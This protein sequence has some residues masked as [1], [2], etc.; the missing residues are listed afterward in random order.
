MPLDPENGQ[1]TEVPGGPAFWQLP[2]EEM[3]RF[4]QGWLVSEFV[5]NVDW[6]NWEMHPQGD[7]L[8]YLLSGDVELHLELPEGLR[9][10]RITGRG[11][12]LI[13][14]GVWHTARVFAPSRMLFVTRG[15]GTRHRPTSGA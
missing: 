10:V 5:C 11:A 13:P 2:P 3:A 6:G 4:D 1:G 12:K 9:T 15:E 7:E 14:R 8:V